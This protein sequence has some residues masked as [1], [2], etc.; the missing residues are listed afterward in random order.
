MDEVFKKTDDET[1][2]LNILEKQDEEAKAEAAAGRPV[3]IGVGFFKCVT[4]E[5]PL[6][7]V[8]VEGNVIWPAG[9]PR[10]EEDPRVREIVKN[11]MAN[12]PCPSRGVR[13]WP[14]MTSVCV[15]KE[16]DYDYRQK[17]RVLS[18]PRCGETIAVD[19]ISTQWKEAGAALWYETRIHTPVAPGVTVDRRCIDR[20]STR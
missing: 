9:Y 4:C 19:H 1:G 10:G 7:M 16:S 8:W 6:T 13:P 2:L 11:A 14:A 15:D 3:I 5:Q 20:L 17:V 12:K 18:C